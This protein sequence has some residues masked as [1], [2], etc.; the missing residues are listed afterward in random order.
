VGCVLCG[1]LAVCWQAG[2]LVLW[3]CGCVL[4][5]WLGHAGKEALRH[6]ENLR[7]RMEKRM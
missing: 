1:V 6:A 4:W 7:K 3:L 5:L 2:T